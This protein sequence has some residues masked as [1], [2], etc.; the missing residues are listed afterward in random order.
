[1]TTNGEVPES[2]PSW[3]HAPFDPE[4]ILRWSI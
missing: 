2:S 1:M 3:C 4:G